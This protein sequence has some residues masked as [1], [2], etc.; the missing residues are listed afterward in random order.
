MKELSKSNSAAAQMMPQLP[1]KTITKRYDQAFIDQ[2]RALLHDFLIKLSYVPGV[3]QSQTFLQ[4]C[5][6]AE[7]DQNYKKS[8]G[9]M[10]T[11]ARAM[12]SISDFAFKRGKKQVCGT[13]DFCE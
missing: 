9:A 8:A 11:S 4:W 12:R 1:S 13:V 6:M 3:L 7:R 2:R 10:T 5:G